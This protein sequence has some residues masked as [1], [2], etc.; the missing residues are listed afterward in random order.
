MKYT[1]KSKY[2]R[3]MNNKN[4]VIT[5]LVLTALFIVIIAIMTI[6][7]AYASS[8]ILEQA[9]QNS[10]GNDDQQQISSSK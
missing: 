3:I 10:C 9:Q 6:D 7:S 8:K 5:S 4:T 2:F 1:I